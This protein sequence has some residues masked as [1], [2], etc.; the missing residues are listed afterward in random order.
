MNKATPKTEAV[1]SLLLRSL[2][3]RIEAT[4]HEADLAGVYNAEHH[5]HYVACAVGKGRMPAASVGPA[6]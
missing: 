4:S 1:P 3:E 5:L 6:V 2:A